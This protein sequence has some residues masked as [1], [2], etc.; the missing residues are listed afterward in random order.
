MDRSI[1]TQVGLKELKFALS[2]VAEN[3][4]AHVNASLSKAHGVNIINGYT[5]SLGNDLTAYRDSFGNIVGNYFLRFVVGNVAYYAPA[6]LTALEG[7]PDT[8]GIIDTSETGEDFSGQGSSSWITDYTSDQVAQAESMNDDVL[9]PHT[10]QPHWSTHGSM[11]VLTQNTFSTLGAKVGSHVVQVK[12]NNIVYNIPA[13][14]RFG[15]PPQVWRS[16]GFSTSSNFLHR[17]VQVGSDDDQTASF[18]YRDGTGTLPRNVVLQVNNVSNGTGAWVDVPAIGGNISVSGS[19]ISFGAYNSVYPASPYYV[20]TV[21]TH[22]LAENPVLMCTLR[23]KVTSDVG[24]ENLVAFS[25]E[26]FF[27]AYDTDGCGFV[28]GPGSNYVTW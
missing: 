24:G 5:D 28:G 15:G 11:T 19:S 14:L 12:Y 17:W 13:S 20:F 21:T 27:K 18:F 22:T 9:I 23:V 1:A 26:C 10:R 8:T 16:F 2:E 6:M 7:Q 4:S 3:L 25:P